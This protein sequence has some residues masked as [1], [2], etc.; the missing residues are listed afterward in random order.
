MVGCYAEF[1]QPRGQGMRGTMVVGGSLTD[2]VRHGVSGTDGLAVIGGT[3]DGGSV[4]MSPCSQTQSGALKVQMGAAGNA[5]IPGSEYIIHAEQPTYRQYGWDV[6]IVGTVGVSLDVDGTSSLIQLGLGNTAWTFG[7]SAAP[8]TGV[9]IPALFVG[10]A[11][12]GRQIDFG[13]AAPT[14][15]AHAIGEIVFNNGD[16]TPIAT[17]SY[18]QCT[19]S[20]T[21]GTWAA[22][23]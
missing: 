10:G 23:A 8:T 13:S 9:R 6:K 22:H 20:G 16:V 5:A 12:G 3:G 18:W 21:P 14:T 4:K 15:G 11:V 17:T 7:R 2:W 1:D 19:A